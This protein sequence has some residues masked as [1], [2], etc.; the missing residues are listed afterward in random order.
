MDSINKNKAAESFPFEFL[1]RFRTAT[2]PDLDKTSDFSARSFD[3]R[4]RL[5]DV[6]TQLQSKLGYFQTRLL[7]NSFLSSAFS[8]QTKTATSSNSSKL[9]VRARSDARQNDYSFKIDSLATA[10]A[11]VSDRLV[12]DEVSEFETGT[13][14][15]DLTVGAQTYSI[16]VEVDNPIGDPV[17]N[18]SVLIDVERSINRLGAGV[19]ASLQDTQ[20]KDYNPYREKAFKD[21]TYLTIKND[22][23]GDDVNFTLTDTTGSLITTLKLDRVTQ[24]GREN[25]YRVNGDA[26]ASDSNNVTIESGTVGAY[27]MGETDSEENVKISVNQGKTLLST[28]L[29]QIIEDV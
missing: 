25:Q 23:T 22:V 13:Y 8:W 26:G 5:S 24:F 14:S 28:E 6:A 17:S 21:V 29:K 7:S 15:Y 27:L 9:L 1:R 18:R 11:A 20:I 2:S 19:T 4:G 10:R 12:S 16:D 3:N